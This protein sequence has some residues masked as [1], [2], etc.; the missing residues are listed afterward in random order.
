M[1]EERGS[2][3]GGRDQKGRG[4]EKDHDVEESDGRTPRTLGNVLRKQPGCLQ[5]VVLESL[6]RRCTEPLNPKQGLHK[7]DFQG[8]QKAAVHC[9]GLEKLYRALPC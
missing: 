4:S 1:E 2:G 8:Q 6:P 3:Q 5:A 7:P 9:S